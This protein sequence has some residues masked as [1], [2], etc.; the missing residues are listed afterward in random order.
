MHIEDKREALGCSSGLWPVGVP[1]VTEGVLCKSTPLS[2]CLTLLL[3][4]SYLT[5]A[6]AVH[7]WPESHNP[8]R[9][10]LTPILSTSSCGLVCFALQHPASLN[11]FSLGSTPSPSSLLSYSMATCHAT[12]QAG[13]PLLLL[14]L[15]LGGL[16]M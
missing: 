16:A 15:P 1:A 10:A 7:A 12:N 4:S 5:F 14:L 3:L 2:W 8:L 13:G 6:L 11:A 9:V